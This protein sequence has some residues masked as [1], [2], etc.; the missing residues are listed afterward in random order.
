MAEVMSKA[1]LA[2]WVAEQSTV[3]DLTELTG[4]R[5]NDESTSYVLTFEVRRRTL[6]VVLISAVVIGLP[7]AALVS[8]VLVTFGAGEFLYL[9][10]VG[11]FIAG[12][13]GVWLFIGRQNRG[14]RLTRYR[15]IL[16]KRSANRNNGKLFVGLSEVT[17]PQ[18]S[19][20]IPLVI[21]TPPTMV[22]GAL[23]P[24]IAGEPNARRAGRRL[25]R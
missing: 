23:A 14:M 18:L 21:D 2:A 7:I 1:D 22:P 20:M 16:D 24:V 9:A 5:K 6:Y 15:G 17:K 25:L 12:A 13:V 11:P 19:V 8:W 3:Y 4:R 10:A